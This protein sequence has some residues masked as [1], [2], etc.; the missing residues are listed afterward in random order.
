MFRPPVLGLAHWGG[1]IC[2]RGPK[3][4]KVFGLIHR[5]RH[6]KECLPW[7]QHC[8]RRPRGRTIL[9]VHLESE[10]PMWTWIILPT[11]IS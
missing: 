1:A 3:E 6:D 10:V 2:S 11:T 9:S 8:L 4:H 5:G 7:G